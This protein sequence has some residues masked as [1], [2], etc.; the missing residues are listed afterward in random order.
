M[1]QN[2]IQVLVEKS[3]RQD[4]SAFALLVAEYQTFVFR[5]AFRLL[6]DEEEA[7]DMVQE[8]FLRVWLSLDKYRP[9]FRFSTWLYRVACNICYDRLRA[10]QHSPAG[11]LSDITFAELPVCSDDNIEATLVNRELKA[12]ILYFMQQL[13]PKQ[14][15]VFTLRDIEELEIKEIEKI[16]GFTSVQIKANLYLARKSIRKKLNEI[17]K[18]KGRNELRKMVGAIKEDS[19]CFRKFGRT[20]RGYY[21]CCQSSA[22]QEQARPQIEL[23]CLVFCYCC[24]PASRFMGGRGSCCRSDSILRGDSYT[25]ALSR[26]NTHR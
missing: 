2:E 7:R 16:T 24:N 25:E 10:L 9:E 21:A 15:L 5:L 14:K 11:A 17:N 12:H 4:A 22:F 20:D 8:T 1:E 26:A 6:C 13:T 3:R 19:T 18:E 23:C